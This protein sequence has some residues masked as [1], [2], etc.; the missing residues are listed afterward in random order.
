VRDQ[1]KEQRSA[2]GR[3][4]RRSSL[5]ISLRSSLLQVSSL[6]LKLV[7]DASYKFTLR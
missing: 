3:A 4:R 7:G 2:R 1:E 6:G 5:R